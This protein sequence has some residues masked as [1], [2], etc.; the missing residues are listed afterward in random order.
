MPK[1]F[2]RI[3]SKTPA[4]LKLVFGIIFTNGGISFIKRLWIFANIGV[5]SAKNGVISLHPAA[6][7]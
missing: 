7:T 3:G 6:K 5:I 1:Y 2:Y 4:I